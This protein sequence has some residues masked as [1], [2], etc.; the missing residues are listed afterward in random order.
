MAHGLFDEVP[1]LCQPCFRLRALQASRLT[2]PWH[3]P[4]EIQGKIV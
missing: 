2:Q 3:T 4:C 1:R